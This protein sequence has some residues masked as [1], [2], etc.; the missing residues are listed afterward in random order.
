MKWFL[1][2]ITKETNHPFLNSYVL[3]YSIEKD[4]QIRPYEYYLA[5]RHDKDELIA[6]THLYQRPDGVIMA[7]YEKKE[8]GIRVLM[9]KQFRPAIGA[10]LTSMPAGLLDAEDDDLFIAAKREAKEES[11]AEITDL[12][13]LAPASPTSSGLSDELDAV[14]LGRIV[15]FGETHLEASEDISARLY[16]LEEIKAMMNDKAYFIPLLVR[17]ILLYLLERFD[18]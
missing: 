4:G 8:D 13:L 17:M 6:K 5:S 12:E 14:V 9:T 11:G 16:T 18:G 10:Y 1:K 3:H 7:L 15:G 2:A